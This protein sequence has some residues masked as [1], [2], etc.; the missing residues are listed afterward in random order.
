MGFIGHARD[1]ENENRRGGAIVGCLV[2][3]A[4]WASVILDS[5]CSSS[6][7]YDDALDAGLP[8]SMQHLQTDT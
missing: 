4:I 3:V 6:T 8:L 1:Q 2:D 5:P 7:N